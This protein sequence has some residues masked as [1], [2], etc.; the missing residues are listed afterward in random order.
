MINEK[1]KM[2]K[3]RSFQ[4]LARR[5]P[6]PFLIYNLSF[7]IF[8][9]HLIAHGACPLVDKEHSSIRR[10]GCKESEISL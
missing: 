6:L 5:A 2:R 8:N 1:L 10:P 4:T 9:C 7:F 3:P